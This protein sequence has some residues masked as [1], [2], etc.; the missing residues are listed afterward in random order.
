VS[1][2]AKK[3]VKL[4]FLLLSCAYLTSVGLVLALFTVGGSSAGGV[5][6]TVYQADPGPVKMILG[7]L[8]VACAVATA[9]VLWRVVHRS[10]RLG[11]AGLVAALP[12]GVMALLGML[13]V[14]P[15]ILPIAALLF[16]VALP[17]DTLAG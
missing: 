4:R 9:S 2:A 6:Q 5:R 15:F 13:T 1:A 10:P 14:G 11:V 16:V 8:A 7:G 17:M 12:V 3:Q